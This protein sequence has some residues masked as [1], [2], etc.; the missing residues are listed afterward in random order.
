MPSFFFLRTGN[1]STVFLIVAFQLLFDLFKDRVSST[2]QSIPSPG[3][4]ALI[5][6]VFLI[7]SQI[8]TSDFS[9]SLVNLSSCLQR[10]FSKVFSSVLA[11]LGSP[12]QMSVTGQ[13]G[14]TFL[15]QFEHHSLFFS[16]QFL[17]DFCWNFLKKEKITYK[18][19]FVY[20]KHCSSSFQ[21]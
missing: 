13:R 16:A 12:S 20:L 18:N 4:S 11:C 7:L 8:L 21:K 10:M 15:L 5:T 3:R 19:Y 17:L 6:E 2:S 1:T 9:F 14:Q